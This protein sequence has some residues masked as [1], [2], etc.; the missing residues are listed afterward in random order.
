MIHSKSHLQIVNCVDWA[1]NYI[2]L[3]RN[4]NPM[5]ASGSEDQTIKLWQLS[6][7]NNSTSNSNNASKKDSGKVSSVSFSLVRTFDTS[8]LAM[9][10][11]LKFCPFQSSTP[12]LACVGNSTGDTSHTVRDD[13][14]STVATSYLYLINVLQLRMIR[15]V[16]LP[17]AD[18][19]YDLIWLDE[20]RILIAIESNDG[21]IDI[22]SSG[23]LIYDIRTDEI[24][25][26][27]SQIYPNINSIWRMAVHYIPMNDNN[28]NI[29]DG[30]LTS[31]ET[32]QLKM[33][34]KAAKTGDIDDLNERA[35]N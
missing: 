4:G 13:P 17:K 23:N 2:T 12:S 29:T 6:S 30:S 16:E 3:L 21:D 22:T 25:S 18:A 19:C 14:L 11:E 8:P 35:G 27:S 10:E 20:F 33:K 34:E 24:L 7:S 31:G 5:F 26:Y 32:F 9:V 15:S 28:T 1:P